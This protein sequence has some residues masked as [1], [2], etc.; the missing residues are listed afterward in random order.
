MAI[1]L[2]LVGGKASFFGLAHSTTAAKKKASRTVE[3]ESQQKKNIRIT[4]ARVDI[5]RVADTMS[6][7]STTNDELHTADKKGSMRKTECGVLLFHTENKTN[8]YE[9]SISPTHSANSI[10]QSY[11]CLYIYSLSSSL[12][13][14]LPLHSYGQHT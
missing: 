8:E 2:W 7:V 13:L 11:V 1:T 12:F 10:F 14:S 3:I 6:A 4:L 5:A 9:R